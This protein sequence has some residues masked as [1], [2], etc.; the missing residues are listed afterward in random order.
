MSSCTSY[1]LP[2]IVSGDRYTSSSPAVVQFIHPQ[3]FRFH[4]QFRL[5]VKL[6]R[7]ENPALQILCKGSD[8]KLMSLVA[9]ATGYGFT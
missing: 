8:T 9:C 3:F 1:G 6:V 7:T 4:I 5:I 2:N